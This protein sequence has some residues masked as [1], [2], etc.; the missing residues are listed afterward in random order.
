MTQRVSESEQG[1]LQGANMSVAAFAGVLSPLFFGAVYSWSLREGAQPSDS[2][3]AFLIAAGILLMAAVL[4]W[5]VAR[6]AEGVEA[7]MRRA[8]AAD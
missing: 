1:Q 7:Q 5:R 2:G 8:D 4:G 3:I 6:H